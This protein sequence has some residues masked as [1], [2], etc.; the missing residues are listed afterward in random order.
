M[1]WAS[2]IIHNTNI[3]FQKSAIFYVKRTD[4][5]FSVRCVFV[6]MRQIRL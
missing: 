4:S 3:V 6:D 2:E 5:A 1:S